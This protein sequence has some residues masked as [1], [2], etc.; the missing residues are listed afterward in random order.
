[1]GGNLETAAQNI[2][3]DWVTQATVWTSP[4]LPTL[5]LNSMYLGGEGERSP[6]HSERIDLNRTKV[7]SK[8]GS[9]RS[10]NNEKGSYG[11]KSRENLY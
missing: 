4:L 9:K 6:G 8:W 3:T 2:N 11:S 7:L 5:F 10:E 1:M